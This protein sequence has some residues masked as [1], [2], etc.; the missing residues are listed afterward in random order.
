MNER[1]F[2]KPIEALSTSSIETV[3]FPCDDEKSTNGIASIGWR[4]P[5]I[6]NVEEMIALDLIFTYLTDSSV[7]TL[8]SHFIQKNS[9]CNRVC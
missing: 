9:V 3:T 2:S 7:S 1:P 4:G 5:H 8:Q 6:S